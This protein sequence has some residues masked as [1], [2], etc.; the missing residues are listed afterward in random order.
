MWIACLA[1]CFVVVSS[2]DRRQAQPT[3]PVRERRAQARPAVRQARPAPPPDTTAQNLPEQA[4]LHVEADLPQKRNEVV[5]RPT[6][7]SPPNAVSNVPEQAIIAQTDRR[8]PGV[9]SAAAK[10][11]SSVETTDKPKGAGK[12]KVDALFE[13]PTLVRIQVLIPPAGLNVLRRTHWGN[14]Q[15]RPEA[16]VTIVEGGRTYTNVALHLKGAAGSFRSV[17]DRPAMTL[18]FDKFANGQSFHGLHKISLNNSVQDS[19]FLCEKIA[20]E[21]FLAAGVPVPRAGHALVTLN[22]RDLGLYV[23][24][25]G[26]NRQ[27]LKRYFSNVNGNFYDGGFCQDLSTSL[28]VTCGDDPD[29]HAG[30]KALMSAVRDQRS[31]F[32]RLEQ[33]LDV[34]R[35][36]S[37]VALEMMLCHW[38]GYTLNRNNW[39]IFHDMDANKIVFI[40]HGL[41]QL[42]GAGRQFDPG[43]PLKP[44]HVAGMVSRAVFATRE[45]QQLYQERVAQLYTNVFKV[46]EIV[47]R[48]NQIVAEIGPEI[49]K[50]H[51]QIAKAF[52]QRAGSLKQRIIQ[53]GEGLRRQLGVPIRPVEFTSDNVM[54][55]TGWKPSAV[56]S[57]EP[58]LAQVEENPG[59]LLLAINAGNA[60]SSSSWRTRVVLG[61]GRYQFAGRMRLKDVVIEDGDARGGAGLRISK[62]N[63]PKKLT[64]TADWKDYQYT[65]TVT[66]ES[67]DVEL[68]C[69]LRAVKGEAW[70]DLNSLR[71]VRLP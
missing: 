2:C 53:R 30:L 63:M 20:R 49:A 34:D 43:S 50:T 16:K 28:A 15:D 61:S 5:Q 9:E 19:T 6:S 33:V 1:V 21:L 51:P 14:G 58:V 4:P 54:R 68:V 17:D 62:G 42:F 71:I 46:D 37:M 23:L 60:I 44:Q 36:L 32:A 69:E 45:G 35:F 7:D 66:E 65:F 67:A 11:K 3:P 70:F 25:E 31:N 52:Q 8:S 56:Q 47:N 10:E 13:P 41:D 55:L 26:A 40:P 12:R 22:G 59:K 39:R 27:F 24:L 18:S 29:N 57:G 64:G 38:D 48:I